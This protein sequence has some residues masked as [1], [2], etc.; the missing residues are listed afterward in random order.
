MTRRKTKADKRPQTPK[1]P[2]PKAPVKRPNPKRPTP[3]RSESGDEN[4][5]KQRQAGQR[6]TEG[7]GGY[8]EIQKGNFGRGQRPKKEAPVGVREPVADGYPRD[9]EQKD[10]ET[11]PE[12]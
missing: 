8:P 1:H 3:E 6:V 4:E 11:E 7:Q 10:L 5:L 9:P 2:A 12:D